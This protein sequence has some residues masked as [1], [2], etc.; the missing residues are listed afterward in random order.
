MVEKEEGRGRGRGRERGKGEGIEGEEE[1]KGWRGRGEGE[2]E[3]EREKEGRGGEGKCEVWERRIKHCHSRTLTHTVYTI[4]SWT[5]VQQKAPNQVG[6]ELPPGVHMSIILAHLTHL[7]WS[8]GDKLATSTD[9]N[10]C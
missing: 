8:L 10:V 9:R 7:C 4:V 2:G 6:S 5:K 1:G 3:E